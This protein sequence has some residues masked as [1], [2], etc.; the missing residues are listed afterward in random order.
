MRVQILQ[1][2]AFEGA[3]EIASVL[4]GWGFTLNTTHWFQGDVAPELSACDAVVV[5]GGPMSVNDEQAFPWL[6]E[7]KNFLR[8]AI[9]AGKPVLGICLGAQ[10]IANAMGARV[11]QAR[12]REIGWFAIEGVDEGP[13][14]YRFP[15]QISVL[16]WHGETFDLPVK[17]KRLARSAVCDNQAFC[18]GNK[19][20]G[21]QFHLEMGAPAVETI[22]EHC[23][24]E[25]S[26]GPFMQ[27]PAVIRALTPGLVGD[28]R[29]QLEQL[30]HAW[31]ER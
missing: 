6:V 19:V 29:R 8:R 24:D 9:D 18:I 17:A 28:A 10:L 22:I 1:H 7:E 14:A 12:E 3:G 15:A 4:S 20:V 5:M 27:P 25:I 21:L 23:R 26:D 31:L 13:G 30:L 11:Y 2:V 16:H